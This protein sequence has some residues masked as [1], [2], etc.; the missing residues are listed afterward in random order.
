MSKT[1][2]TTVRTKSNR[3]E[4]SEKNLLT[5]NSLINNCMYFLQDLL[6]KSDDGTLSPVQFERGGE[7][8]IQLLSTALD[9]IQDEL[10][11]AVMRSSNR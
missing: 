3:V 7:K 4:I 11:D 6:N 9:P 2:T 10:A 1:K 5:I 8:I